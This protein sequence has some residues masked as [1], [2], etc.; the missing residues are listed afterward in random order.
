MGG[1]FSGRKAGGKKSIE[2]F[3]SLDICW[4]YRLGVLEPGR[5]CV[6]RYHNGYAILVECNEL[7]YGKLY[8]L[9]IQYEM[10]NGGNIDLRIQVINY[11]WVSVLNGKTQRPYF[12][13]PVMDVRAGK[14]LLGEQGFVH[15]TYF[16]NLY[17][18]QRLGHFDRAIKSCNR[19]KFRLGCLDSSAAT[20]PPEK[21]KGMH[22][23]TYRKYLYRHSKSAEPIIALLGDMT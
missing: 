15:R 2:D 7:V 1:Y 12:I 6:L 17:R 5:R 11:E 4:L 21:P 18:I 14:L 19:I 23:R 22:E 20:D 16:D 8:C 13:C 9:Y 3:L 10:Q